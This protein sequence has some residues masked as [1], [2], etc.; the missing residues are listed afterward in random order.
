MGVPGFG[1]GFTVA[2]TSSL[3]EVQPP[4]VAS[5]Q[6]ERVAVILVEKVDKFDKTIVLVAESYQLKFGDC[7]LLGISPAAVKIASPG[8]QITSPVV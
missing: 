3:A 6:K 5:T 2:I 7:P 1:N 8:P 4:A